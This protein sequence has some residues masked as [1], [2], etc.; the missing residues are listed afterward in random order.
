MSSENKS[1]VMHPKNI[2]I[3]PAIEHQ[4]GGQIVFADTTTVGS[5]T[6]PNSLTTVRTNV[7][8]IN[9][10]PAMNVNSHGLMGIHSSSVM[11][12]LPM[13]TKSPFIPSNFNHNRGYLP[14][15][16]SYQ[17]MFHSS[18][19]NVRQQSASLMIPSSN[20]LQHKPN[21][22]PISS[23]VHAFP[24][25]MVNENNNNLV[26]YPMNSEKNENTDIV[27]ALPV[28]NDEKT[29]DCESVGSQSTM[30]FIREMRHFLANTDQMLASTKP[31]FA[32]NSNFK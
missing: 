17:P 6:I 26:A 22:M 11:H 23:V 15:M 27:S 1:N 2:A 30:S 3:V 20:Y 14:P 5:S 19:V 31:R 29:G 32:L 4:N 16:T 8:N 12:P 13:T 28:V 24:P 7:A 25:P 18:S 9:H 21:A 10:A